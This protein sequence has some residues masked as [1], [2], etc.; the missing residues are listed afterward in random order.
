M[1]AF[2]WTQREIFI[3]SLSLS[4]CCRNFLL[5]V[6][7]ICGV[8]IPQVALWHCWLLKVEIFFRLSKYL[9]HFL[10]LVKMGEKILSHEPREA[11]NFLGQILLLYSHL[12]WET[13]KIVSSVFMEN[14]IY[15]F[16]F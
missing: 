13:R 8:K 1:D 5:P 14:K 4:T 7:N 16:E 12:I 3:L 6:R 2:E 9:P 15:F 10:A 11:R